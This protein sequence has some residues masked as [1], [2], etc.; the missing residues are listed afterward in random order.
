MTVRTIEEYL[1][2]IS[3]DP[4]ETD[5]MRELARECL[6]LAPQVRI[7]FATAEPEAINLDPQKREDLFNSYFAIAYEHPTM[8][9]FFSTRREMKRVISRISEL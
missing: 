8:R 7:A 6:N 1:A 5:L 2:K 3:N 4:N 9:K